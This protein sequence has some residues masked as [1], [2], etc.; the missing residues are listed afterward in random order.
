MSICLQILDQDTVYGLRYNVCIYSTAH[1]QIKL[2]SG[3]CAVALRFRYIEMVSLF[4]HVLR[5]LRTLY[6]VLSLVRRRV[7]LCTT[8]L[9]IAKHFKTFAVRLRLIFQFTYVQYCTYLCTSNVNVLLYRGKFL[10]VSFGSK[11]FDCAS[12]LGMCQ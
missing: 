2:I 9:K 6:I 4:Y 1:N 12:T 5:Y 7:S 11:L 10:G 3:S 8:F